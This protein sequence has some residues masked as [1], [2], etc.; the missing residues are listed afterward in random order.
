MS[1]WDKRYTDRV[2]LLVDILP[3]LAK[4]TRFALKGGT[5]INLFEHDLPRLSVDIDLTWL[6]VQD[7]A[8]DVT[9]ISDALR[10]LAQLLSAPPLK[11]QVQ[12]SASEKG[13]FINRLIASR[14]RTRVQIETTPVMRGTVHPVRMMQP[15]GM[16]L[17]RLLNN[18]MPSPCLH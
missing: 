1:T 15:F 17:L 13:G 12:T 7:F 3:T 4:E 16:P 5:A 8:Q 11:L 18:P 6:P 10:Q 14:G 9:Q 2:Q